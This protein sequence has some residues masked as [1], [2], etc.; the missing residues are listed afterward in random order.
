MWCSRRLFLRPVKNL[1]QS[2]SWTPPPPQVSVS[3]PEH[4][5]SSGTDVPV[6]HWA[7]LTH[8]LGVFL[9][10]DLPS[11]LIDRITQAHHPLEANS[12]ETDQLAG[13]HLKHESGGLY[14]SWLFI[15]TAHWISL[16]MSSIIYIIYT[17]QKKRNQLYLSSVELES[18]LPQVSVVWQEI[19]SIVCWIKTLL[20]WATSRHQHKQGCLGW[21]H[22]EQKSQRGYRRVLLTNAWSGVTFLK[23]ISKA[24]CFSCLRERPI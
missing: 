2:Y 21:R 14:W 1:W 9:N 24:S 12:F 8:P 4:H 10:M 16:R 22:A 23:K 20:Y 11:N 17:E 15:K 18:L 3:C 7:L 19:L 5:W 13:C 6:P